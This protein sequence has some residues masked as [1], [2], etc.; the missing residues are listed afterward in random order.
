MFGATEAAA[1]VVAVIDVRRWGRDVEFQ[2]GVYER[3]RGTLPFGAAVVGF[4]AWRGKSGLLATTKTNTRQNIYGSTDYRH[5]RSCSWRVSIGFWDDGFFVIIS[6]E[7][8]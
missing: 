8:F 1:A 5:R 2:A 6:I 4:V 3:R 7:R